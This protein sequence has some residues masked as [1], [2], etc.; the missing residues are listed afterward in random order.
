MRSGRVVAF[1]FAATFVPQLALAQALS[2]NS[3]QAW[4]GAVGAVVVSDFE[5]FSGQQLTTQVSGI[6]FS[7]SDPGRPI[8]TAPAG[9]NAHSG[10]MAFWSAS[11]TNGGGGSWGA[12][13]AT[14]VAGVAFW[15]GGLQFPGS[16]VELLDVSGQSI[17]TF[18]LLATGAGHGETTNGFNGFTSATPIGSIAVRVASNDWVWHDDL[19]RSESLGTMAAVPTLTGTTV[20]LLASLMLCLGM[21][22]ARRPSVA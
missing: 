22:V 12:A 10:T 5:L 20:I 8:V 1:M 13:F 16:I 15:T 6:T 7:A 17:A 4:R 2:Y 14:P 9:G 11:V 3:E 21:A 19:Q 18:D